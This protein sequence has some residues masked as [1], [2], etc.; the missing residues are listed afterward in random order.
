MRNR[1]R[2]SQ[3]QTSVGGNTA[4]RLALVFANVLRLP[5]ERVHPDLTPDEVESWD[6]V[7][8]L[9]L[10]LA[11]E[12]EFAI[13]CEVEEIMEFTSFQAILSAIERR[14]TSSSTT[15]AEESTGT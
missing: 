5:T 9:A 15:R 10:V 11:V 4:D 2:S 14:M 7:N 1:S 8:H 13:Q 12:Q 6:S 3:S